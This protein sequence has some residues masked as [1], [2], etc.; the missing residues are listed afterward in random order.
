[1]KQIKNSILNFAKQVFYIGIDTHKKQWTIS[2]RTMSIELKKLSIE[3][4]VEGLINYMKR[5]YPGGEYKFVYE[6]GFCGF[7]IVR[8]L[9][10]L[11]YEAIVVN[12]A[13]VP[14]MQKEKLTKTDKID[15]GKLSRE[16]EHGSLKGI[17]I[18]TCNEQSLRSYSRLREQLV[19]QQTRLINRIKGFLNLHG[20]LILH[21]NLLSKKG[22]EFVRG[23]EFTEVVNKS[24]LET[25]F[26]DLVDNYQRLVKV[27]ERI[28]QMCKEISEIDYLL[29]IPGIG[30]ITAFTLYAELCNIKRFKN[31]SNLKSL[32]GFIP[33]VSSSDEREY[34]GGLTHRGNKYLKRML[35]QS[36]W[37]AIKK[38]PALTLAYSNLKKRMAGQKAI[39]TI[40][41]KLL[42]RIRYCWLNHQYYSIAV[43]Q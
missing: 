24:Y 4:N 43:V 9:R 3:P 21:K 32:I 22:K 17:Y 14:T 38:D 11:G 42:N 26:E 18:P 16:Y 41:K 19:N 8:K 27:N 39:I 20:I 40:V 5:N 23:L 30:A 29:S 36:A 13:D 33:I 7:W 34:I 28:K 15:S 35:V 2:I 6:A 37:R 1:M 10:E 25:L 12:A 31:L